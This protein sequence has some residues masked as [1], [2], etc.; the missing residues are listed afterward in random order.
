MSV[1]VCAVSGFTID[2]PQE[3][4]DSC[5]KEKSCEDAGELFEAMGLQYSTVGSCYS[6][7][8]ECILLLTP[9]PKKVDEQ[10]SNWLLLVNTKLKTNFTID[11]VRF[12]SDVYWY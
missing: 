4:L 3:T 12:I 7:D 8:T 1:D 10:I 2:L 11:D 6:G 5:L 9:K